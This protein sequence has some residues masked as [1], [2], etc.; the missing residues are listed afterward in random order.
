MARVE[1]VY[2]PGESLD[3]GKLNLPSASLTTL[4]VMVPPAF[5]ALTITPSILPS[6]CELTV[7]VRAAGACACAA[8]PGSRKVL[9]KPSA[10]A[11]NK[12]RIRMSRSLE[13]VGLKDIACRAG[14]TVPRRK[15]HH[16]S[17]AGLQRYSIDVNEGPIR[18]IPVR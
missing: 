8:G 9:A 16:A 10:L 5:L 14:D 4:M 3:A 17:I 18:K 13:V 2:W 15:P 11:S 12:A 6:C 7:P 1:I